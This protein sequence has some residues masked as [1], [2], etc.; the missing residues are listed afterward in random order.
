MGSICFRNSF[1]AV[2]SYKGYKEKEIEKQ[3]EIAK[4]EIEKSIEMEKIREREM[5]LL[6]KK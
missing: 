6:S 2:I 5:R 1:G 4:K 3:A